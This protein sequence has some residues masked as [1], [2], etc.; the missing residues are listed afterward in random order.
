MNKS[1]TSYVTNAVANSIVF[2]AMAYLNNKGL[3]P[4]EIKEL[5]TKYSFQNLE[6]F[7][8]TVEELKQ[9]F[10]NQS[11]F[12]IN[13]YKEMNEN[14]RFENFAENLELQNRFKEVFRNYENV[15]SLKRQYNRKIF[16]DNLDC[17]Y[18][19]SNYDEEIFHKNTGVFSEQK[20][21]EN[22]NFYTL[23][24]TYLTELNMR[25]C[26]KCG[27]NKNDTLETETNVEF[28]PICNT[29]RRTTT[30]KT[31]III[32]NN[33]D[34]NIS[35]EF[36]DFKS[37]LTE[38]L[39]IHPHLTQDITLLNI[40][41]KFQNEKGLIQAYELFKFPLCSRLEYCVAGLLE[42]GNCSVFSKKKK[43]FIKAIEIEEYGQ[44]LGDLFGEGGRVFYD[45][46]EEFFRVQD[47]VS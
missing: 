34:Y 40:M 23:E 2:Y 24:K 39:E 7:F 14:D 8:F 33:D 13:L 17:E 25:V 35:C 42:R 1:D 19:R 45:D 38:W 15:N 22:K 32:L 37:Y 5:R 3:S 36:D 43:R 6:T 26:K 16:H 18:M 11:A 44:Q 27:L 30:L 29:V 20:I 12:F 28:T 21:I 47:W 9:S 41:T 10:V 31:I 4:I 46:G